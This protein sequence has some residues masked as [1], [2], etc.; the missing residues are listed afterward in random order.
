MYNL[1]ISSG[2]AALVCFGL[3]LALGPSWWWL[4]LLAAGVAF[5][6]SFVLISRTIMKKVEAVMETAMKDIQNQRFEKGVRELKG[7]LA[8]GKWQI[9]VTGQ[10]NATIGMVHYLKRDFSNAF[11]YLEKGFFKNWMAMGMLAV[12]HMKRNR[13]DR[14][15]ETFEKA[16]VASP[17]ESLLWALYAYC[18]ADGG[19]VEKAKEILQ[20]GLKKIPGDEKL[21]QNLQ[22]LGDGKKMKMK[23]Y[24]D[25]WLQFHLESVGT[26]QKQQMAALGVRRRVIRR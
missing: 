17:K 24:G 23:E 25:L 1:L 26:I 12:S 18:L 10:V 19:D 13:R 15:K 21:Q 6:A 3:L 11:P 5:L 16:V 20:R 8:Y 14:M 7:A 22:L 4:A 2:A 9:Y